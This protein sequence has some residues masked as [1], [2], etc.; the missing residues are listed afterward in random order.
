MGLESDVRRLLD[1][2]E[3][4]TVQHRLC[5]LI[6]AF[7]LE[8]MVEEIFAP[9]GWDDHGTGPVVG[10]P[11]LLEW[12][13]QSTRNLAA[14]SH[15]VTNLVVDLDGDRAVVHS[16]VISWTWTL[17]KADG[18]PLHTADYALSVR[19]RDH[20]SRHP[21]GWRIDSRELLANTSKTGY[22]MVLAVGELP[23]SQ[24]GVRGLSQRTPPAPPR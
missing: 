5:A 8:R 15:N 9:E 18:D 1:H 20:M 6:D 22:A 2:Q 24:T 16:N 12:Y 14:V 13:R 4:V 19:Y 11:A 17:E 23:S 7:D 21:E 3:I 10:R